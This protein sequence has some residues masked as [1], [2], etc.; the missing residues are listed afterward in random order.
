MFIIFFFR[1]VAGIHKFK[2]ETGTMQWGKR[3]PDYKKS[4]PIKKVRL[5]KA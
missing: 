3:D 4:I 1:L 2:N 5:E